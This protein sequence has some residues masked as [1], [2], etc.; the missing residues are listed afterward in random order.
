MKP[1]YVKCY[2]CDGSGQL[3]LTGKYAETL[4]MLLKYGEIHGALLAGM[5]GCKATAMNNRLAGLERIGLVTSRRHG[6]NRLYQAV[7][8][9]QR[10]NRK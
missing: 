1:V 2:C 6:R 9:V 3:E 7:P 8:F 5:D 4:E 10:L